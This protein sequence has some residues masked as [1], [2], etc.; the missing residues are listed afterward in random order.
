MFQ[1]SRM[2]RLQMVLRERGLSALYVRDTANIEWICGFEG[3]FDEEQAHALLI[4]AAGEELFLHSDSRYATALRREADGTPVAVDAEA[5]S[6]AEWAH[7]MWAVRDRWGERGDEDA[8]GIEQSISLGEYRALEQAFSGAGAFVETE[9]LALD[10]RAVKDAGEAALL[11]AAQDV[12]DAAFDHIC[13]FMRPSMTECEVQ[14]ELD[15]WMLT[16]GA[17]GLAF[18]SIVASGPNGASPHAI[19][20]DRVLGAGE[21]VV[22]DFGARRRGYCSD[23]TRTVFLGEPSSAMRGAYAALR[24][25]HETVA[26]ALKPGMTGKE[27]HEMAVA[28]LDGAGYAGRM[29]HSLGHGVGVQ[30]HEEPVLSPRN[31]KPLVE[32]NVVTIEPGIY[33]PGEFGM[34]LED[35]G[36]LERDGFRPFTRSTH[37]PVIL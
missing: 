16:H 15:A 35:L 12:T 25:A 24:E 23:M 20:S 7:G 3:V 33:L 4:P 36:I 27:A 22:M 26:E 31:E 37:E 32:G 2:R 13:S 18:P 30:I 1:A 8:L 19:V 29:G 10:A 14:L 6:F 21:C 17:D 5:R 28:V 34:R 11:Q 9:R